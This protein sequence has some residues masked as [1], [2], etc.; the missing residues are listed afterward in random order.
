MHITL[1]T[2][3]YSPCLFEYVTIGLARPNRTHVS[4]S[5]RLLVKPQTLREA[6]PSHAGPMSGPL[7]KQWSLLLSFVSKA[8]RTPRCDPLGSPG[9]RGSQPQA[10]SNVMGRVKTYARSQYGCETDS[11][12]LISGADFGRWKF[13]MAK[14]GYTPGIRA[15]ARHATLSRASSGFQT[16]EIRR[17]RRANMGL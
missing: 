10:D 17:N 14:H 15:H 16:P 12:A 9:W 7:F 5:E 1:A 4:Q 8:V 13:G 3:R 2:A 6:V 11:F